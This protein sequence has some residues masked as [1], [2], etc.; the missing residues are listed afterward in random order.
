MKS[1]E[2]STM[3][4]PGSS[5][6]VYSFCLAGEWKTTSQVADV[7]SPYDQ[8]VVGRVSL[9][10]SEQV[11]QAISAAVWAA[12]KTRKLAAYE[13]QRALAEIASELTKRSEEFAQCI[14]AESGNSHCPRRGGARGVLLPVRR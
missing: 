13:R 11:Q 6:G 8:H 3:E 10:S 12:A 2:V 5:R 14:A 9:A 4:A 1:T 7:V